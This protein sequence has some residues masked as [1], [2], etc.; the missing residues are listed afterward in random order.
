[1][2]KYDYGDPTPPAPKKPASRFEMW[3]ILS[4]FALLF[5]VCLVLYF[6]AI[7]IAPTAAYNPLQPKPTVNPF[8][9]ATPT[10]TQIQLDAIWTAT[11]TFEITQTPTLLPTFTL[12]PSP[13][14][15]SLIPSTKTLTPTKAPKAPFSASFKGID[16]TIIHPEFGC[17][18]QAI[19]GTVVGANNAD[20]IG[21][22]IRLTGFYNGKVKGD[23][24]FSG[25]APAYGISGFELLLG[26]TPVASKGEL[27]LQL[28]DQNGVPQSDNLYV[29]TFSD[30][31]QN[32]TLVRFV[33]NP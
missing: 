27:Y 11:P 1:M 7:F 10:I 23:Q 16:S 4:V 25:G 12:E 22:Q 28:L 3:D 32:L 5:T 17:N 9:T 6:A 15:F 30:C 24:T 18:W 13:T 14:P 29:D 20:M 8:A 2:S 21:M 19:G 31:A 33:K 26:N